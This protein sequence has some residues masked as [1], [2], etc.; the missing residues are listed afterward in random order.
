MADELQCAELGARAAD[1]V[2]LSFGRLAQ[3]ATERASLFGRMLQGCVPEARL[4]RDS[5]QQEVFE[6]IETF[7]NTTRLHSSLGYVSPLQFEMAAVA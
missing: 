3:V 2:L 4:T 1:D 6:Y 7:Y 5:V